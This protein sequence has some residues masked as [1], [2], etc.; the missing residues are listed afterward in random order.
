MSLVHSDAMFVMAFPR[1]CT[2][3]FL[4]AHVR[5]FD[6]VPKRISYD[7]L[8]IAISRIMIRHKR[9]NTAEFGRLLGHYLFEPHFCNVRRPNEKGVVEGTVRY[10]RQNFL[11][12]VPQVKDYEQL[13]RLLVD[14]CQ[15]DLER[16][17]RGN[18]RCLS[19]SFW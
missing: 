2:E 13:N 18:A 10:A 3:T 8:R 15:S 4:E 6:F 12:P 17:L 19:G 7:N 16:V 9:K 5:A 11:M 14:C 1:E